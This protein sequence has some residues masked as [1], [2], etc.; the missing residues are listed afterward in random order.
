MPIKPIIL[1]GGS[2]SRLWPTSRK[3][4]PKQFIPFVQDKCLLELTIERVKA[5]KNFTMP[6][7]VGSQNHNFFITKVL[8]KI[9][10]ESQLLLEPI[11]KNTSAAIYL[12]AL[13][14]KPD[15]FM[16]IMPS[17]HLIPNTKYFAHTIETMSSKVKEGEWI[18]LGIKPTKPSDS[19]GYIEISK[20]SIDDNKDKLK[21]VISF[22]EKPSK[23]TALKLLKS[24]NHYWNAGIFAAYSST[25]LKS[26]RKHAPEI[27]AA[28]DAV[29]ENTSIISDTNEISFNAKM[30]NAIPSMSI[31]YAVMEKEKNIKLITYD[32]S[33]SDIG[34]WDS[35]LEHN[36]PTNE[37]IK[38]KI[39]EIDSS[40]NSII[41]E[42]ST[43]ATIGIKNTIIIE[44]DGSFLISKKGATEKVKQV[45]EKLNEKKIKE[46]YEHTFE[47]RPWGKF[48]VLLDDTTCKLKRLYIYPKK[49]LS[50][51]YHTMRS[52]HWTVI[53]GIAT[54]YI[55]DNIK[56]LYPGHSID[57]P[58]K[59]HHYISNAEET[60]LIIIETQMGTYFG[61]DDIIR[62][63]DPYKR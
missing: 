39:I 21:K 49:R 2:G 8:N 40:N 7:I 12:S 13:Y 9:N 27:A 48:E 36:N 6:L 62:I 3:N 18:T 23:E 30:F 60:E 52:E 45:V 24:G 15:D 26:I 46:A 44:N 47:F 28:C 59:A 22:V 29:K 33:W 57:I 38:N 19:Y 54:V 42:K 17:D 16:L 31:D 51:Q 10:F 35:F 56:T 63:D 37:K 61:V 55:N 20:E 4:F 58:L 34:S 53:S 25:I 5:F 11:S 50:L 41:S 32:E 43:I 14:S 1:C